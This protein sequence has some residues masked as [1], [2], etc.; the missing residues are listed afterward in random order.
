MNTRKLVS[1]VEICFKKGNFETFHCVY[2]FFILLPC[3]HGKTVHLDL[4]ITYWLI[5]E[6]K[7]ICSTYLATT[8][9]KKRIKSVD[10]TDKA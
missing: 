4:Y 5:A 6:S 2:S 1:L 9:A 3:R 10:S 8:Y 7:L